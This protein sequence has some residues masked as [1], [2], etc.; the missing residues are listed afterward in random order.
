[1]H[2]F[3][4]ILA[5]LFLIV[6]IVSLELLTFYFF[7][8]IFKESVVKI[9]ISVILRNSYKIAIIKRLF[10][11]IR[12]IAVEAFYTNAPPFLINKEEEKI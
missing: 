3:M 12:R 1:M 2:N 6:F 11:F 10:K 4:M 5:A 8:I 7:Y 9:R